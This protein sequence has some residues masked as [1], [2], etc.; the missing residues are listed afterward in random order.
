VPGVAVTT[1]L[2]AGFPGETEHD[3][4]ATLDLVAEARFDE[5]FMF[6]CSPM[7]GTAAAALPDQLSAAVKHERLLRLIEI[8]NGITAE[9]NQSQVGRVFEVLAESLSPRDP[10]KVTGLTRTNKTMN[11]PGGAELIGRTVSVLA[12]KPFIWGFAGELPQRH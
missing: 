2:I 1:D 4:Q 10:S 11:F 7:T 12:V 6:A 3:F 9:I 8:Q 5:A